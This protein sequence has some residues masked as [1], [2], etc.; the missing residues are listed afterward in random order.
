MET[1][2][3]AYETMSLRNIVVGPPNLYFYEDRP[4]TLDQV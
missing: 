2:R 4:P 1:Q 3:K